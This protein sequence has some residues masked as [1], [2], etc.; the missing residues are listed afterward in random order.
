MKEMGMKPPSKNEDLSW[1]ENLN[2]KTSVGREKEIEKNYQQLNA[3]N[4][5]ISASG[6]HCKNQEN[7]QKSQENFK[8]TEISENRLTI[9]QKDDTKSPLK[10]LFDISNIK[11]MYFCVI[12]R[13]PNK[14]R[15]QIWLLF[16]ISSFPSFYFEAIRS[17]FSLSR[18]S[19]FGTQ[20]IFL[21]F[22][23]SI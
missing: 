6:S 21:M 7:L 10:M 9:T 12:K 15:K 20:N 5:N 16:V 4:L 1:R 3:K 14:V 17:S 2:V 8:I 19:I 18:K 23:L 13:R 11:E 22:D